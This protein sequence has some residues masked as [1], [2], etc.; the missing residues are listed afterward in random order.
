MGGSWWPPSGDFGG[1]LPGRGE[2]LQ[3]APLAVVVAG[4]VGVAGEIEPLRASLGAHG[5]AEGG[6]VPVELDDLRFGVAEV[7]IS[8][9]DEALDLDRVVFPSGHADALGA[10]DPPVHPHAA[11]ASRRRRIDAR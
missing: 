8:R 1:R 7:T 3:H 5:A 4:A 2:Q 10:E 11:G 9:V 6:R